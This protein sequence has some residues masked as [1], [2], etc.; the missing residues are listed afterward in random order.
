[1]ERIPDPDKLTRDDAERLLTLYGGRRGQE[2]LIRAA[3]RLGVSGARMHQLAG[4][5]RTTVARIL[6]RAT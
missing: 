2:R 4:I 5:A 1:M 6:G 3:D